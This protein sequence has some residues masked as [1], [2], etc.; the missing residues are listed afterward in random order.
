MLY[1]PPNR[2]LYHQ[3]KIVY[4]CRFHSL[5]TIRTHGSQSTGQV[6]FMS[7]TVS[8]D[9]NFIQLLQVVFQC[10]INIGDA[11]FYFLRCISNKREY[12]YRIGI[13]NRKQY[14]YHLHQLWYH[15]QH[16]YM[17]VYSASFH[18]YH[19]YTI[20]FTW[21]AWRELWLQPTDIAPSQSIILLKSVS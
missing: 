6:T 3:S 9:D 13:W 4:R 15:W 18:H 5:I 17:Y 1:L 21:M 2:Q 19:R 12:Q 20:P 8:H 16:L 7:R 11:Y 14:N 10:Y